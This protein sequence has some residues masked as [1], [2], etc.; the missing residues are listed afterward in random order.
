MSELNLN[1]MFSGAVASKRTANV[2]PK[3][4]MKDGIAQLTKVEKYTS[5]KGSKCVKLIFGDVANLDDATKGH[6]EYLSLSDGARFGRVFDKLAYLAQHSNNQEAVDSFEMLPSPVKALTDGVDAEGNPAPIIF[7][8]NDELAT[9]RETYGEDTTFVWTNTTNE[10]G[11]KQRCA[12]QF[13]ATD[14]Y[15]GKYIA[16]MN[17]FVGGNYMLVVGQDDRGFQNLKAINPCKL[18]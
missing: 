7:T 14:E 11:A 12:I 17:Q 4:T 9:I 8:T 18:S 15:I 2:A 13:V 3:V 6:V 1:N 10:E 16:V 5:N